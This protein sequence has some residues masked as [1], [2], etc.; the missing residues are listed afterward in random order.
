MIKVHSYVNYLKPNKSLESLNNQEI[1]KNEPM[2]FNCDYENAYR[3]G[4]EITK[5]GLI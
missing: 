3:L 2:L 5:N 1:I 4:G